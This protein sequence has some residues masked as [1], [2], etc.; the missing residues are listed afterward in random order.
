M[1]L[2]VVPRGK[3][4]TEG[5][6]ILDRTETLRKLGPVLE[7]FELA[8]RERIVI[9]DMGTAVGFGYAKIS[10]QQGH[11]PR[12]HRGSAIGMDGQTSGND[13][14]FLE[15]IGNQPFGK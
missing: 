2:V 6:C 14:L 5:A 4:L 1:V 15:G 8:L 7:S 13:C 10:H 11:R 3:T 9:R 12:G